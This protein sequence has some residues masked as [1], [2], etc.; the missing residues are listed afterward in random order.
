MWYDFKSIYWN[1]TTNTILCNVCRLLS[2]TR[3]E[4]CNTVPSQVKHNLLAILHSREIRCKPAEKITNYHTVGEWKQHTENLF[5]KAVEVTELW[6]ILHIEHEKKKRNSTALMKQP[7]LITGMAILSPR[8]KYWSWQRKSNGCTGTGFC[9]PSFCQQ[10]TDGFLDRWWLKNTTE[11][12]HIFT[13]KSQKNYN[14][15][16][17]EGKQAWRP[18]QIAKYIL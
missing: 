8:T 10:L 15:V 18:H 3:L 16:W 5:Q 13:I 2:V 4:V 1:S 7:A 11:N 9:L 12:E 6:W 14:C 17:T